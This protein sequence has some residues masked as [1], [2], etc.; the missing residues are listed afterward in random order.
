MLCCPFTDQLLGFNPTKFHIK[1]TVEIKYN[2]YSATHIPSMLDSVV[3]VT[4]FAV[5]FVQ[6][7][8]STALV[9][10]LRLLV[11]HLSR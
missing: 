10:F 9:G 11:E 2:R 1:N 4:R 3:K 8:Y 7:E 5:I 6:L